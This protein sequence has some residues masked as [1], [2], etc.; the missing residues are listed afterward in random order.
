MTFSADLHTRLSASPRYIFFCNFSAVSAL[1]PQCVVNMDINN[2]NDISVLVQMDR[3]NGLDHF[4]ELPVSL[5]L[6]ALICVDV[7]E[8]IRPCRLLGPRKSAGVLSVVG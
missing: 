4:T 8:R 7:I 1:F 2:N 3:I 5:V 6:F